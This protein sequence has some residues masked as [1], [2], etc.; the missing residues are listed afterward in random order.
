M[1]DAGSQ[2]MIQTS[3]TECN[4]GTEDRVVEG[5]YFVGVGF[6]LGGMV[7]D[8][9]TVSPSV[10][11]EVR[12]AFRDMD[13]SFWDEAMGHE[14]TFSREKEQHFSV[15]LRPGEKVSVVQLVGNYGPYIVRAPTGL[16]YSSEDC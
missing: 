5:D 6:N 16:M 7:S 11:E 13:S 8:P 12:S 15:T 2:G 4:H 1:A 9:W 10:L 14:L 3:T